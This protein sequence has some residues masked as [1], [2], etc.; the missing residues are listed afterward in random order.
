V[1]PENATN[2][3]VEWESGNPAAA[4]VAG[5]LVIL[6]QPAENV[7]ITAK[8][9]GGS[10]IHTIKVKP[11]L[12]AIDTYKYMPGG[13][14][15]STYLWAADTGDAGI[16]KDNSTVKANKVIVVAPFHIAETEVRYELWYIVRKWGEEHGYTFLNKGQ[17]GSS[18]T[19]GAL[20]VSPGKDQPVA[21]V[22]WQD[23]VVW[24]NAYSELMGKQA[25]YRDKDD[26][27]VVLRH[28]ATQEVEGLVDIIENI[29]EYNGY[30]LPTEAE[31]EY[32]ARGGVPSSS[33][34][35]TY[36]YAGS[37]TVGDVAWYTSNS[38]GTT[39]PVGQKAAN[40]AG[41][42]DMSGNVIEWCFDSCYSGMARVLRGG[43]YGFPD[44]QCF[45]SRRNGSYRSFQAAKSLGFRLVYT[46]D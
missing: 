12:P 43:P 36:T 9:G 45:V 1:T 38:D 34:P 31:W 40:T 35:W 25:A 13:T 26:N 44:D 17:P 22:S 19:P 10:D 28:A 14:I 37:N 16:S 21:N 5:G 20:P 3:G 23:A 30:R 32:A 39:H 15:E 18:G 4:L 29:R 33:E 6:L 27:S 11:S 42:Y 46:V 24:C 7:I 8:A 41:L 2:Q